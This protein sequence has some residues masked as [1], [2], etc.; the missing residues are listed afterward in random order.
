MLTD[1]DLELRLTEAFRATAGPAAGQTAAAGT[2]GPAGPATG[3]ARRGSIDA[4]GLFRRGVARR[5][6]Q[7]AVRA[8]GAVAAA[9]LVAGGLGGYLAAGPG[10]PGG[11]VAARGHGFAAPGLLLDAAVARPQA[12]AVADAGMPRYYV[13]A[14]HGRPDA[15][16]RASAT[17]RLLATIPLPAGIDPKLSQIAAGPGGRTFVLA[18]FTFPRTRFYLLSLGPGGRSGRLSALPVPALPAGEYADGLAVSPGGGR[19]AVAIQRDGGQRGAIEIATL[20]PGPAGTAVVRI[21]APQRPGWPGQLS[22]AG[23]GRE[24]GFFWQDDKPATAS[25]SGLWVL[26]TPGGRPGPARR[27]LPAWVGGDTVESALLDPGGSTATAAVSYDGTQHVGRGTVTGGIVRI[28]LRT[29]RPVSTLLAGHAAYSPDAGW[30]I[31]GCQLATPDTSG[32]H[33][34]VS[35]DRFGRLDLARFTPLPGAAA[36]TAVDAAW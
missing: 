32:R 16:V 9:A 1:Q 15:E 26:D 19:L 10:A 23:H 17:G 8:A 7:V 36:Q 18:L 6:R 11:R 14:D 4:A 21:W 22:W 25:A 3:Q 34:L 30:H 29:G 28:S 27:I 20:P 5:R 13:I 33:L 12:A 2:T 31:T 24:L 35:C